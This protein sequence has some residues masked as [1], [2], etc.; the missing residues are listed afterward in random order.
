MENQVVVH[1]GQLDSLMNSNAKLEARCA[2]LKLRG[3]RFRDLLDSAVVLIDEAVWP[4][5]VASMRK[6]L[7]EDE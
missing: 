7:K 1:A 6:A 3:D 2:A 5:T 4:K